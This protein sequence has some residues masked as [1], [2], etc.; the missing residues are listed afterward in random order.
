AKKAYATGKTV[1]QIVN[2]NKILSKE[3]SDKILN[4][5]TMVK[6]SL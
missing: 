3:K 5:K 1:R 4:P 2:E 6:P